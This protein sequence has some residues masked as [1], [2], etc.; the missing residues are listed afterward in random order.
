VP[1]VEVAVMVIRPAP[2]CEPRDSEF[3]IDTGAVFH[4]KGAYGRLPCRSQYRGPGINDRRPLLVASH[5]P[6][7]ST[8]IAGRVARSTL[9]RHP[10]CVVLCIRRQDLRLLGMRFPGN[11]DEC[12]RF[13][14]TPPAL[15]D[16]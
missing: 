11:V 1:P 5:G 2:P 9:V 7:L 8:P 3:R 15:L 16:L 6:A 4:T 13:E 10:E 14:A 12:V